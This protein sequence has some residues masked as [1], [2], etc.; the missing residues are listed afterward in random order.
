MKQLILSLLLLLPLAVLAQ[1]EKPFKK[2]STIE[3][4][5]SLTKEQAY[6]QLAFAM[7][8]AGYMIASSD[9]VLGSITSEPMAT[10]NI[11][12]RV[13]ALVKGDSAAVIIIKGSFHVPG[14]D[15][16]P[17]AIEYR[18]MKDSPFM[19]AWNQLET[20]ARA[21]PAATVTYR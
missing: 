18:G 12:T 10:K 13:N 8:E 20:V 4:H 9:A 5:T 15:N 11:S 21:L 3:V 6:Q 1:S 16:T 7:Q 17:S 19:R 14:L 2:A